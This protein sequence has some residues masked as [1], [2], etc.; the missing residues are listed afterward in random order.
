MRQM[1]IREAVRIKSLSHKNVVRLLAVS[2]SEDP[3]LIVLELMPLG[4]L[5]TL[6]RRLK[7]GSDGASTSLTHGFAQ[8]LAMMCH[9]D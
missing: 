6:L 2:L 8:Y 1:F 3:L 4:D 7:S 5:K 9:I